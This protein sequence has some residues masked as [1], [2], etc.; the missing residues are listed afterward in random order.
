MLPALLWDFPKGMCARSW[1]HSLYSR[2]KL[3]VLTTVKLSL[4]GLPRWLELE[5]FLGVL[6]PGRVRATRWGEGGPAQA[7]RAEVG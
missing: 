4:L 7:E 1:S 3:E 2:Q 5:L 6:K